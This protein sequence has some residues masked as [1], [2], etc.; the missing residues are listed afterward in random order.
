MVIFIYLC[1]SLFPSSF[2]LLLLSFIAFLFHSF[3][4]ILFCFCLSLKYSLIHLFSFFLF[5]SVKSCRSSIF[6]LSIY[7]VYLI[8]LFG[9]DMMVNLVHSV[10]TDGSVCLMINLS[11]SC[12][13]RLPLR[14]MKTSV[15]LIDF[16]TCGMWSLK[17]K[18]LKWQTLC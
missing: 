7:F 6:H 18:W 8:L 4:Y 14:L 13:I 11:F 12:Q 16:F 10:I 15:P 9:C 17:I 2:F 3:M 1:P 5:S